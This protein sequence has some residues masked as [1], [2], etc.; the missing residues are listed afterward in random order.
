MTTLSNS[1]R[2][3][4]QPI[5]L[6]R[7][8]AVKR[9][10][11][12]NPNIYL[13]RLIEL[14]ADRS[15]FI[16]AI[17]GGIV[18]DVAGFAA[19]VFMRGLRYGFVSPPSYHRLM[20]VSAARTVLISVAI[21]IW[22]AFLTSRICDLWYIHAKTLDKEIFIQVCRIIKAALFKMHR[23]WIPWSH[24]QEALQNKPDTMEKLI[25]HSVLI[26]S[27]IVEKDEKEKS[28]RKKLNFGHTFAH[29]IEH[30]TGMLT[31]WGSKHWYGISCR[32]VS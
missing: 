4:Y 20:Q 31:W 9:I 29:A 17:G 18:C 5:R 23:F 15:T 22:L 8:G 26:K 24:Y 3:H 14:E 1:I 27:R 28:E 25:Y 19:S 7:L 16:V 6:L 13:W 30:H 10:N 12:G 21:R 11:N 2:L 32:L